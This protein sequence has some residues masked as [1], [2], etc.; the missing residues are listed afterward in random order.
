MKK[1]IILFTFLLLLTSAPVPAQSQQPESLGDVARHVRA[2][3]EK[4][5]K[6]V[7]KVFT[8]DNLPAS[9]PKMGMT[10]QATPDEHSAAT[11]EAKD[12]APVPPSAKEPDTKPPEQ[13][14][15]SVK[16][17]DYWQQ[18]FSAARQTLAKTKERQQLAE[19]ELNLLQIQ[20]AREMDPTVQADLNNKVQA[21]QSEVDSAKDATDAAQKA[22]DDL[23]KEFKDSGAP[24]DWSGTS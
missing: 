8:N 9:A 4:E 16:T 11:G 13:P 19:D 5:A 23:N 15:S 17:R 21:K 7:T 14:E 24:D 3:Q 2:Q 1:I 12:E 18:K 10:P 20:Q 6:K 22:L